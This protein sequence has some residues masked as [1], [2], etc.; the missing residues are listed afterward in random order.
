M[1]IFSRKQTDNSN[2]EIA[3]AIRELSNSI[4]NNPGFNNADAIR[5]LSN[6]ILETKKKPEY[7]DEQKKRAAYALNM[8]MISISQI[9]DYNDKIVLDQEYEGILNN[10]NLENMPKDE[11][12][13]AV[14]KQILDTI[15]FFRQQELTQEFI[16]NEYKHK[17]KNAIW[18][19]IPN[20]SIILT[21]GDPKAIALSLATQ[22]GIGYMNYR[23]TKEDSKL[24]KQR[25]ELQLALSALEQL[26]ILKRELFETAWR[27]ADEY[28]FPDEYRITERQITMYNQILMDKNPIRKLERLDSIKNKFE[29]YPPFWYYMGNAAANAARNEANPKYITIAEE[30]YT[31]YLKLTEKPLLRVDEIKAAC[32]IEYVELALSSG[33]TNNEYLVKHI[34]AAVACS[35]FDGSVLQICAS[36]YLNLRA[37]EEAVKCFKILINEGYNIEINSP[38]L[39]S[40]LIAQYYST[41]NV[42]E[43]QRQNKKQ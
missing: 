13:L 7:T 10:I 9:I 4:N 17:I 8:C 22:V 26:N 30:C 29:A 2:K 41:D 3:E 36:H 5:E 40:V 23:R 19:A 1:S 14:I 35:E 24:E 39:A 12:L 16:E 34:D 38:M 21:S 37:F 11:A 33:N 31:K 27:L 25:E 28:E 18:S 42:D 6:S 32:E 20:P 15:T 43:K